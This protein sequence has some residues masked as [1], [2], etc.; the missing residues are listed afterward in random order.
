MQGFACDVTPSIGVLAPWLRWTPLLSTGFIVAGT[1]LRQPMILWVFAAIALTGAAGWHPFDAVFNST[2]RHVLHL[3]QLPPNPP[4]RR[5]AMALAGAW[6]LVTG[7]FFTLGWMAA[8]S[9][10]GAVL[11]VAAVTV[12]TTHFCFGSLIFNLLGGRARGAA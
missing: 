1:V 9:V 10:A 8:G 11:A 12:G 6:A 5:F 7:L 2:L 3:P 4:P